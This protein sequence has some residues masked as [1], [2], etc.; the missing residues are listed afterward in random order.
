MK[1]LIRTALA[2][3]AFGAS[4]ALAQ[5]GAE[6]E[7]PQ[8]PTCA[9]VGALRVAVSV[10]P[11]MTQAE[12]AARVDQAKMFREGTQVT[13]IPTGRLPRMLNQREFGERFDAVIDGFLRENRSVDGSMS[14]M[15]QVNADG[16]V[17]QVTPNTGNRMMDRRMDRLWREA[18]FEPL[19]L[20]GC[21]ARAWLQTPLTFSSEYTG[22]WNS[23]EART[24]PTPR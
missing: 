20:G 1:I 12:T 23:M 5:A 9:E 22:D 24:T 3:A 11:G 4:P 17:E 13:Y 7:R 8:F 15:L 6:P 2:A 14:I 21:R 19:V 10:P 18:R 16:V